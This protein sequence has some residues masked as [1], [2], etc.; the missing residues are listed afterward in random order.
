L[1]GAD[2][3]VRRENAGGG[4]EL[5][6]GDFSPHVAGRDLHFRI[7]TDALALA[8]V[9]A[10]HDVELAIVFAEPDRSSNSGAVFTER[11]QR[12]V[13]LAMDFVRNQSTHDHIVW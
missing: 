6:S 7:V 8:H 9:A 5:R 3:F 11:R 2:K 4:R 1:A 12:N 10:S 13:L